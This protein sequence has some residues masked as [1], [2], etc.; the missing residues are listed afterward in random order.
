MERRPV[1]RFLPI[2]EIRIENQVRYGTVGRY[3]GDQFVAIIYG[4]K[5]IR[6]TDMEKF[7]HRVENWS[8]DS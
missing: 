4:K 5:E 8:T 6:M 7:I 3:G 2:W 1:I